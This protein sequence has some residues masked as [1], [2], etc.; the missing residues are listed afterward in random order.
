M[1]RLTGRDALRA[2]A[3]FKKNRRRER[4]QENL[5]RKRATR[6]PETDQLELERRATLYEEEEEEALDNLE[7]GLR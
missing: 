1:A 2:N 5:R 6:D 7:A 4:R 3:E